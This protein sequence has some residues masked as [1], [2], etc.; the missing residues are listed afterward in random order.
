MPAPILPS[1]QKKMLVM[2][3]QI[4]GLLLGEKKTHKGPK[5]Q[6]HLFLILEDF[7]RDNRVYK[8]W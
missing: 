5:H 7:N 4:V 3:V 6:L 8:C 2:V 1:A